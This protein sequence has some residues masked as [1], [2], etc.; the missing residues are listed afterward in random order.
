[1]FS[2]FFNRPL[3][4]VSVDG[5]IHRAAGKRLYNECATLGGCNTGDAKMTAG[6]SG[7]ILGQIKKKVCLKAFQI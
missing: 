4:F 7:F 5:A 6:M 2:R 3:I 1:M